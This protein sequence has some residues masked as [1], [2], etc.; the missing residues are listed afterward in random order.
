MRTRLRY[1]GLVLTPANAAS[2]VAARQLGLPAPLPR[3]LQDTAFLSRLACTA[4]DV[5][6][7]IAADLTAPLLNPEPPTY[8]LA[9][10]PVPASS[11]LLAI[12]NEDGRLAVQDS[13]LPSPSIAPAGSPCHDNAVFDLAWSEVSADRLVTVAGD[14][15]AALWDLAGGDTALVSRLAGHTRSVKCVDWRPGAGAEFATGARDNTVLV[16]DARSGTQGPENA[17]RGAHE[18]AGRIGAG[19]RK[20]SGAGPG[21]VT[22][23]VWLDSHTLVSAGD[24]DGKVKVWDLRK[25]YSLYRGEPLPRQELL[26]P[27]G[28]STKGFTS[29]SLGPAAA[30]LFVSCM[31]DT[32]YR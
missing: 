16:W 31:D 14:Q 18:A 4:T 10:C 21:V 32:V 23:L 20:G 22:G 27:G 25:N 12:A 24:G 19:R 7:A 3:P 13:I 30:Q 9:W 8:C 29:L 2:L 26:H 15:Q 1:R 5:F 11:H 17:V 28:S 6:P